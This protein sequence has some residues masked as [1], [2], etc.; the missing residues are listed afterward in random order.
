MAFSIDTSTP[1]GQRVA[2]RLQDE[3]VVWLVT[4][5][6]D[7]TP[8][9]SPVWFFWDGEAFLIYSLRNTARE[10]NLRRRPNVALHFNDARGADVVVFTGTA[11]IDESIPPPHEHAG[12]VA[13]Y[14]EAM[15][16]VAG[17]T[18]NFGKRYSLPMRIRPE[19]LRGH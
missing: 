12:Y 5:R 1:F 18:E 11:E 16:R 8:E 13:K 17:A 9:P 7:G 19:T 6:A 10:L 3:I 14:R 2:Q 15:A 4:S